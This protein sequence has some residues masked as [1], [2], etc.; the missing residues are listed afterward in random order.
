[1]L[2]DPFIK[3]NCPKRVIAKCIEY[4]KIRTS[5]SSK[6]EGRGNAV[7]DALLKEIVSRTEDCEPC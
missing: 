1:M 4:G 3:E 5:V 2:A 6:T 7:V